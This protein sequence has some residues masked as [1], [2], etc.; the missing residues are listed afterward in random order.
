MTDTPD[1]PPRALEA[2]IAA[3]RAVRNECS[4]PC[5]GWDSTWDDTIEEALQAAI[6]HLSDQFLAE[7]TMPAESRTGIPAG[8]VEALW[9]ALRG[10]LT[11]PWVNSADYVSK[12]ST[13]EQREREL[14][15]L[16][17][18]NQ[19]GDRYARR[20]LRDALAVVLPHLLADPDIL[21]EHAALCRGIGVQLERSRTRR[22]LD[23]E[24]FQDRLFS[25]LDE[26][27]AHDAIS[28]FID[29]LDGDDE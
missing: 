29:L 12:N 16:L 22:A 5:C 21:R 1:I 9:D 28:I 11:F 24:H 23:S 13:G 17:T 10:S 2:A 20:R 26:E 6:P 15:E 27:D 4:D 25:L 19:E 14:A 7:N 8:A 3:G 18:A